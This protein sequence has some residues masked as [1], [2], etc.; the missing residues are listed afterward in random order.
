MKLKKI[1]LA[2][3]LSALVLSMSSFA[4]DF[5][6]INYSSTNSDSEQYTVNVVQGEKKSCEATGAVVKDLNYSDDGQLSFTISYSGLAAAETACG[7]DPTLSPISDDITYTVKSY[8]KTDG[9]LYGVNV[10][11]PAGT[12]PNYVL[13]VKNEPSSTPFYSSYNKGTK[14]LSIPLSPVYSKADGNG[15]TYAVQI[16]PK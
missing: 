7:F 16:T 8:T 10:T 11:S 12:D 6:G 15:D 13:I 1:T 14:E 9:N 3:G 4:G 5:S 2:C